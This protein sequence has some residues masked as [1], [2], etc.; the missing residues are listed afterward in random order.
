MADEPIPAAAYR[1]EARRFLAEAED[2]L[3]NCAGLA[4]TGSVLAA[5]ALAFTMA[6][7]GVLALFSYAGACA[8]GANACR[9]KLRADAANWAAF[10]ASTN[11]HEE[12]DSN[13]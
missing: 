11:R 12:N 10:D 4:I 3:A 13:E 6:F 2:S 1:G 8:S 9:L 7:L 5:G